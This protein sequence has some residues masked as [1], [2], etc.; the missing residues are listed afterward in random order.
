MYLIRLETV[1]VMVQPKVPITTTTTTT[2]KPLPKYNFNTMACS[3]CFLSNGN[4]K[5]KGLD[6]PTGKT[7]KNDIRPLSKP[8]PSQGNGSEGPK[9][10]NKPSTGN[11]IVPLK[12]NKFLA[13]LSN[14]KQFTKPTNIAKEVKLNTPFSLSKRKD[15]K[16]YSNIPQNPFKSPQSN[17]QQTHAKAQKPSILLASNPPHSQTMQHNSPST[18]HL[19]TLHSGIPSKTQDFTKYQTKAPLNTATQ[20][21]LM[22]Q[23]SFQIN[24]A[25]NLASTKPTAQEI[26]SQNAAPANS[27]RPEQETQKYPSTSRTQT[28]NSNTANSNKQFEVAQPVSEDKIPANTLNTLSEDSNLQSI[29]HTIFECKFFN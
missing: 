17:E 16:E 4:D 27:L 2:R 11:N 10:E 6:G 29:F 3:G 18:Q 22:Q 8:L 5:P 26:N 20:I 23:H 19:H 14:E 1:E 15:I 12:E 9:T 25:Q 24:S 28:Q 21:N 7:G 13:S